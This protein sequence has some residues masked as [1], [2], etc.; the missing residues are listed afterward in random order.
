LHV[1]DGVHDDKLLLVRFHAKFPSVQLIGCILWFLL[2]FM[3]LRKPHLDSGLHAAYLVGGVVWS[4]LFLW[5][6]ASYFLIYWDLNSDELYERRMWS[7]QSVAYSEIT[8]VGPWGSKNPSS[9]YLDIEYGQVGSAFNPRINIIACPS[10][11]ETFLNTLR[12]QAL[13]AEFTV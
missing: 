7:K 6:L 5:T 8:A 12:K 1:F 13:Q 2:S 11:R 3:D 10:D 9:S 4:F